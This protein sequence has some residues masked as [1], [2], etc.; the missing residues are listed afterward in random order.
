MTSCPTCSAPLDEQSV[1]C[2]NCGQ[3]FCPTCFGPTGAGEPF[4][5]ACDEELLVAC[6]GC[7]REVN[8]ATTFCP[9]CGLALNRAGPLLVPEYTRIRKD[10]SDQADEP[11]SGRCPNCATELYI[12]DGFCNECGQS[13]CTS[14]GQS[15]DDGDKSCPACGVKLFFSCPLCDFELMASTEMCPNCNALFPTVCSHCGGT[16]QASDTEC[17]SCR[18]P[19]TIQSRQS[20]RTI[21]TFLVGGQLIRM[22]AC[23]GCGRHSNPA[24]GPCPNCGIRVCAGCQLILFAEERICPRCGQHVEEVANEKSGHQRS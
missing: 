7:K 21:R 11:Y 4:C 12:E 20:A 17:P 2:S 9:E 22:V 24:K 23:P 19:L 6:T 8:R 10:M 14:C 1:T 16:V 5:S 18:R 13:L 15:V 3:A